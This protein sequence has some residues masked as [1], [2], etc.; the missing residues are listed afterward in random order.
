MR[1]LGIV[2][3]IDIDRGDS[4]ADNPD[5]GVRPAA[6]LLEFKIGG[7]ACGVPRPIRLSE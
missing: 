7:G 3:D 5:A 4:A 1:Q 2:G 6:P